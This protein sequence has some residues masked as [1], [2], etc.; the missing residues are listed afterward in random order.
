MLQSSAIREHAIFTVVVLACLTPTI[1]VTFVF[2]R[3]HHVVKGHLVP[4]V[5]GIFGVKHGKAAPVQFKLQRHEGILHVEHLSRAWPIRRSLV[6]GSNKP[7]KSSSLT[8]QSGP[9]LETSF[10][11]TFCNFSTLHALTLSRLVLTMAVSML[12]FNGGYLGFGSRGER[13]KKYT[14]NVQRFG[15][16]RRRIVNL[17]L[18]SPPVIIILFF[19]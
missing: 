18:L 7:G 14:S 3:L 6:V 5:I 8:L 1:P 19:P 4:S 9:T 10:K 16:G 17:L 11:M 15:L 13:R 2:F 12:S